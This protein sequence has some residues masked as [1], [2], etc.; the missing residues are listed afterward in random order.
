MGDC[1]KL[2]FEA[3]AVAEAAL[4]P[5]MMSWMDASKASTLVDIC[6]TIAL[7]QRSSAATQARRLTPVKNL[8]GHVVE[9]GIKL[10]EKGFH[11]TKIE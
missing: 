10:F 2:A 5:L 8:T 11:L 7:L 6:I 4:S 1:G 3:E 9:L